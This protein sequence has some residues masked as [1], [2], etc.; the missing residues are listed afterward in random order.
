MEPTFRLSLIAGLAIFALAPLQAQAPLDVRVVEGDG[1]LN[2]TKARYGRVPVVEVRDERGEPVPGASIE[3]SLPS[4]GAGGTFL[5]GGSSFQTTTDPRGRAAMAPFKP[6]TI[7]GRF[8]IRVKAKQG[9]S[10]GDAVITQAN[11]LA[12]GSTLVERKRGIKKVLIL[13]GISAGVGVAGFLA[14]SGGGGS[15]S[16]SGAA[17]VPT[18]ISLGGVTVGAPR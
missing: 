13:V 7:E 11:S 8:T 5:D 3:F 15:G 14:R 4:F 6:N 9:G 1:A 18:T 2:N 12:G 17:A 10:V 16:G